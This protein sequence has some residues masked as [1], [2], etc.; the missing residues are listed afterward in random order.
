MCGIVGIYNLNVKESFQLQNFEKALLTMK[1]RGPDAH[2]IRVFDDK[3]ILG[4]VRLSIIDLSDNSNQPFQLDNRYWI[5]FNGEIYNYL[6]LKDELIATGYRF[7]T[8]SDTEVLVRA[9]QHWGEQCVK[10]FNGMWAFAI[11]DEVE[12]SLF[13]SRDRFGIKPFNYATV[14]G[15]FIFSSEIKSIISCFPQLKIPNYNV[16][17]NYCR[18]S[19]G[20]QIKETWFKSIYRLE[21]AHN[22]VINGSGIKSYRYWDYPR[23]VNK[24][25]NFQEAVKQYLQLLTDA[26]H[27]RMRSDVPVGFTLSSGIDSASLVCLLKDHFNGNKNTYTAAF[28]NT[29]FQRLEKQNFRD[30]VEI[31]EPALVRKLTTELELKPTI[32]N[33]NFDNYVNDLRKI[34]RHMESGHGSPAV[35]PLFQVLEEAKKDV[36]VVL[37]G[38]GTD[39]LLG[40]YISSVIFVYFMELIRHCRFGRALKELK[41]FAKVYSL[42]AAFMLFIRESNLGPLKRLYYYLSDIESFYAGEIKQYKE[43]KDYPLKPYGFDNLLNEYLYKVHTGG[44]VNLLHYGDAVSMAHSI[45]SRLPFMDYRLVEFIFTLPSEY[46]VNLGMGKH[47][48]RQAMQGIVPEYIINNPIKFGFESPLSHIFDN[49]D[50]TSAKEVLLSDRCLTRG[51]FSKKALMKAFKDHKQGIKNQSRLLYRMLSVELWFQ[52]FIDN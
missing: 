12:N 46:K 41:S 33:I 48:H 4:H 22:M 27:L 2:A 9:Y 5:V 39:E 20:A 29:S 43:I 47:L 25:I 26:V 18:K 6:E 45:E 1:H 34:I 17:A 24:Q 13:C 15:Q 44:L 8:S 38:Q 23:K 11:Y 28:T 40:G 32:I 42:R 31:D 7:R 49:E 50:E 16:I 10:R 37:E 35:F 51:L 14:N 3:A 30:D 36:T 19:I 52:E 21:P